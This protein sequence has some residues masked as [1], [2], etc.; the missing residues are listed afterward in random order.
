MNNI[1]INA[2]FD[3][4]EEVTF[5]AIDEM[6]R[7]VGTLVMKE[8]NIQY[9]QFEPN[10]MIEFGSDNVKFNVFAKENNL[11]FKHISENRWVKYNPNPN[12]NNTGDC[13]IRAYCKA[14]G[15]DWDEAYDIAS[16]YGKDMK[17]LPDDNKVVEKI[18]TTEFGYTLHKHKKDSAKKTVNEFAVEH[19]F[20][21]YV[22]NVRHHVVAV[23]DG[24]F[25][26]TWDSGKRSISGYYSAG[27][28]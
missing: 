7:E 4:D 3:I 24:R 18:M 16:R 6:D 9:H 17:M 1:S 20:G 10:K 22:V 12:G 2:Q 21:T 11:R 27:V 26:D 25:Y 19:P 15:L 8:S 14:E 13:T 28:E 5:T 23:V